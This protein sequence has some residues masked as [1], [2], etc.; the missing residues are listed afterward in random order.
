M[1]MPIE[2]GSFYNRIARRTRGVSLEIRGQFKPTLAN[3]AA[4]PVLWCRAMLVYDRQTN[5]AVPSLSTV[6]QDYDEAGNTFN[7]PYSGINMDNRDRFYVIRDR[8]F[9]L[10]ALGINGVAPTTT[11]ASVTTT[12]VGDVNNTMIWNEFIKLNGLETQYK[13]NTTGAVGD[14][15]SGNYLLILWTNQSS[16]TTAWAFDYMARY[17]FYD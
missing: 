5:G 12:D 10:P 14:I 15:A 7:S 1:Q 11:S 4:V 17:K 6:L 16:G 13:A 3:S 8:K 9:L 2:G